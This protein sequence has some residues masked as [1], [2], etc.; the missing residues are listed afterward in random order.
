MR[1]TEKMAGVGQMAAGIAHEIR[2]PLTSISGAVQLIKEEIPLNEDNK[3][4]MN[5]IIKETDRL[6]SLL[7]DFLLFVQPALLFAP[8]HFL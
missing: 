2:N 5:I 8:K 6:N 1:L 4:L 3:N 7:S